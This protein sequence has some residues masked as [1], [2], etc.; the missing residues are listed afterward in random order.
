VFQHQHQVI[1]AQRPHDAGQ[2]SD[3]EQRSD[4]RQQHATQLQR[5]DVGHQHNVGQRA[6]MDQRSDISGA[7]Q[8]TN[9]SQT[10]IKRLTT[11]LFCS[12]NLALTYGYCNRW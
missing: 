10:F 5:S 4:M 2:R 6:S 3:L 11:I 8:H 9:V 7:R 12:V 1:V